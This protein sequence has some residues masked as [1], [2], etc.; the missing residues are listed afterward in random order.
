[1]IENGRRDDQFRGVARWRGTDD[2]SRFYSIVFGFDYV[3][4]NEGLLVLLLRA[5]S[6][7]VRFINNFS[8]G[9]TT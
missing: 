8:I 2:A 3:P 6:N 4:T 1:M 9:R 5:T 7:D